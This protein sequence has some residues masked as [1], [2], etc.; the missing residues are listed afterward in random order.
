MVAVVP[1]PVLLPPAGLDASAERD[2][3][4]RFRRGRLLP[5]QPTLGAM[6]VSIAREFGL[7]ST[8]GI[9]VYL[10]TAGRDSSSSD[11]DDSGPQ[12]TSSSWGSLFAHARANGSPSSTPSSTPRKS[13]A[14]RQTFGAGAASSFGSL[15]TSPLTTVS[16]SV[17]GRN[18][19]KLESLDT[20]HSSHDSS[21]SSFSPHTPA[22]LSASMALPILASIEFDIEPTEARW[23]DPW[24]RAGG[25]LRRQNSGVRELTLVEK[26]NDARPKF[27]KQMDDEAER[28]REKEEEAARVAAEEKSKAERPDLDKIRESDL[29]EQAELLRRAQVA[30]RLEE[31]RRHDAPSSP[32]DAREGYAQLDESDGS[33]YGE[34]A[35]NES[36]ARDALNADMFANGLDDPMDDLA[37]MRKQQALVTS[38]P[39]ALSIRDIGTDRALNG[40]IHD[41]EEVLD[42]PEEQLSEVKAMLDADRHDLLASPIVLPRRADD[43]NDSPRKALPQLRMDDDQRGSGVVMADQITDLEKMMRDLSPRELHFSSLPLRGESLA[44]VSAAIGDL[45]PRGTS[46]L[47]YLQPETVSSP[48]GMR[49]VSAPSDSLHKSTQS[50]DSNAPPVPTHNYNNF[51]PSPETK[52]SVSAPKAPARPQRPPTPDLTT[53]ELP[54]HHLSQDHVDAI[55]SYPSPPERRASISLRGIRRRVSTIRPNAPFSPDVTAGGTARPPSSYASPPGEERKSRFFAFPKKRDSIM[56]T[57]RPATI[58]H[59]SAPFATSH[60]H[61]PVSEMAATGIAAGLPPFAEEKRNSAPL[62]PDSPRQVRRKPVPGMSGDRGSQAS[63][64]S[65]PK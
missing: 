62:S 15:T 38:S 49:S 53:P 54:K 11:D 50:T 56:E 14:A 65:N 13:R 55:K 59:I 35:E 40:S 36:F 7:P 27:M 26:L 61:I 47:P 51:P 31:S 60:K 58:T 2:R 42:E 4:R 22:S 46:K 23:L 19:R 41:E 57:S 1:P 45:P 12:I 63:D 34:S 20:S 39:R 43:S 64:Y 28:Q 25:P 32:G 5:L 9:H 17:A 16:E 8:T 10:G 3:I 24:L 48:L 18:S 44:S 6:L 30:A 37:G 29:A 33:D 21:L 52:R